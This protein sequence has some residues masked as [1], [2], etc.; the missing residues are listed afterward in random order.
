MTIDLGP[1]DMDIMEEA[2]GG[3][4]LAIPGGVNPFGKL[5]DPSQADL[6][7]RQDLL[8]LSRLGCDDDALPTFARLRF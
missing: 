6:T 8:P 1:T 3:A 5:I 4:D 7:D 2:I